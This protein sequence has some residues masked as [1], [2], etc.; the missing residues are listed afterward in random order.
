M[1]L[2]QLNIHQQ[3]ILPKKT[4]PME[5]LPDLLLRRA[6]LLNGHLLIRGHRLIFLRSV[7]LLC[8]LLSRA[9]ETRT[10][11]PMGAAQTAART[12]AEIYSESHLNFF[13]FLVTLM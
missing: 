4:L 3:E 11:S 8:V 13:L 9:W 12:V 2:V 7:R 5:T 6:L 1:V 10:M